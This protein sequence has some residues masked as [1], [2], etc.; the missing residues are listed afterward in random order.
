MTHNLIL[1]SRQPAL[2][3]SYRPGGRGTEPIFNHNGELNASSNA[4]AFRQIASLLEAIANGEV[5][6]STQQKR[7]EQT[8]DEKLESFQELSAAFHDSDRT[9]WAETGSIIA[10]TLKESADRDGFF[11]RIL[12]RGEAP[13]NGLVRHRVKRKTVSALVASGPV[14]V[15]PEM[16]R[17]QYIWAPE[18]EVRAS[19]GVTTMELNQGSAELLDDKYFE[20]EEQIMRQ[21]DL[22]F[23]K[24]VREM[25][26]DPNDIAYVTGGYTPSSFVSIIYKIR[27]FGLDCPM[28]LIASDIMPDL[29]AA[30][31]FVAAFDPVTTYENIMS[32]TIAR[33]YG[34]DLVT[35]QTRDPRLKVLNPGEMLAF[36]PP[37][38]VGGYTDRGPV[39]SV[40][41][42]H[43]IINGH[44]AKGWNFHEIL[45]MTAHTGRG[46]SQGRR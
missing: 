43:L 8:E 35:D 41:V 2:A 6:N 32:G 5:M 42:D 13:A 36:G 46:V 33:L 19:I 14:S 10:A 27:N 23:L 12:H 15:Q 22:T 34:T 16:V 24:L 17:G 7:V 25:A 39:N 29:L 31:T 20:A 30:P 38:Y 45:S 11:R 21:E 44:S 1:G 40:P 28:A 18:F 9:L 26:G 37:E 4:D 3:R